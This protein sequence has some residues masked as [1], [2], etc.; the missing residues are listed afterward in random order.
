MRT[1]KRYK[2]AS[3]IFQWSKFAALARGSFH[4]GSYFCLSR[5]QVQGRHAGMYTFN[6]RWRIKRESIYIYI[7]NSNMERLKRDRIKRRKKK[8]SR[9]HTLHTRRRIVLPDL[10]G[11]SFELYSIFLLYTSVLHIINICK[12]KCVQGICRPDVRPRSNDRAS[13]QKPYIIYYIYIN[14]IYVY[15]PCIYEDYISWMK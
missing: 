2:C 3:Y 11:E 12:C 1:I 9:A 10:C 7:Y 8:R 5:E 13:C 15:L 4:V 6:K 14:I